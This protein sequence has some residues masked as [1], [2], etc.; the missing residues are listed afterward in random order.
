MTVS[1][2]NFSFREAKLF[3]QKKKPYPYYN[4]KTLVYII[5]LKI[6]FKINVLLYFFILKTIYKD[7]YYWR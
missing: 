7:H 2:K 3:L 4:Y 5:S 1:K 6:L